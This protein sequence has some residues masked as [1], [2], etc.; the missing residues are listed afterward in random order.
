MSVH[1]LLLKLPEGYASSSLV[2]LSCEEARF[3]AMKN[4]YWHKKPIQIYSI[5]YTEAAFSA[6]PLRVEERGVGGS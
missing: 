6:R 1:A 2:Y 5:T 3:F 4:K